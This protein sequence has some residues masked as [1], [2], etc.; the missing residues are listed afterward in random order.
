MM[1]LK[2]YDLAAVAFQAVLYI[3]PRLQND[4]AILRNLRYCNH[5]IHTNFLDGNACVAATSVWTQK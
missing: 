5:H 2:S 3:N 4:E 1:N